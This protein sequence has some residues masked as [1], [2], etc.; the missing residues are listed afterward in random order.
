MRLRTIKFGFGGNKKVSPVRVIELRPY[1]ACEN[2]ITTDEKPTS[3][4]KPLVS[5]VSWKAQTVLFSA[6]RGCDA[7]GK[8][9][10][11]KKIIRKLRRAILFNAGPESSEFMTSNITEKE[12][13]EF[14]KNI[15]A[16]P[17][18][19]L[20]HLIHASEI[21]GYCN[22]GDNENDIVDKEFFMNFYLMMV[23]AFHMEPE[24]YQTMKFRLR[25]GVETCCHKT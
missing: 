8:N 10:I 7:V 23:K 17:V 2:T 1:K 3:V 6:I 11:S 14:S 12:L 21:I 25:D 16:Y 4:V 19:F 15:D 22:N 24:S 9:D 18:H 5:T 20:L 13:Y